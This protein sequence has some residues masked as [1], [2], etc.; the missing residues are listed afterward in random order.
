MP[1][2][3]QISEILMPNQ[4]HH[5][6]ENFESKKHIFI[7]KTDKVTKL[8]FYYQNSLSTFFGIKTT[9]QKRTY[10]PP[11][12]K[13]CAHFLSGLTNR[14]EPGLNQIGSKGMPRFIQVSLDFNV[15]VA[16]HFFLIYFFIECPKK[17]HLVKTIFQCASSKAFFLI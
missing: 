2:S 3:D 17:D 14:S 5:R 16:Y 7:S 9:S 1:K 12:L 13:I 4:R 10:G 6:P 15:Q 8:E 11:P